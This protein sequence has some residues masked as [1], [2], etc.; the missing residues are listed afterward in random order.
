MVIYPLTKGITQRFASSVPCNLSVRVQLLQDTC[1]Q[2]V[3]LFQPVSFCAM[4]VQ[5]HSNSVKNSSRK[6]FKRYELL[7]EFQNT[8]ELKSGGAGA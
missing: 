2:I 3:P 6:Y 4:L 8:K 7:C 1:L 5:L